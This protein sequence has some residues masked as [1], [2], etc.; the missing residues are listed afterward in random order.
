MIEFSNFP[1]WN[2][3]LC[4]WIS[5]TISLLSSDSPIL[6][7]SIR[8]KVQ[9]FCGVVLFWRCFV[10]VLFPSVLI[11]SAASDLVKILRAYFMQV[12]V[13]KIFCRKGLHSYVIV[14]I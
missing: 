13:D 8:R 6:M 5:G 4:R 9:S 14:S 7:K 3:W 10:L 1:T 2:I 12:Q 11:G